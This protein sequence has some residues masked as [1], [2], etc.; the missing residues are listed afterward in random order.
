MKCQTCPVCSTISRIKSR[1]GCIKVSEL[2]T[3][4]L[5]ET[6]PTRSW[7]VTLLLFKIQKWKTI[8][9]RSW[10]DEHTLSWSITADI[11]RSSPGLQILSKGG[12]MTYRAG[13]KTTWPIEKM[14]MDRNNSRATQSTINIEN[15]TSTYPASIQTSSDHTMH[16]RQ[17]ASSPKMILT[18][19]VRSKFC[20]P[21]G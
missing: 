9:T 21:S 13:G 16:R 15:P 10:R 1:S 4:F 20:G 14:F 2:E 3:S 12:R 19:R 6:F 5:W 7:L 18:K 17:L 8:C 11:F